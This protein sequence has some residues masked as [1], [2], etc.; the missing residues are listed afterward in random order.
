VSSRIESYLRKFKNREVYFCPNPGNAGDSLI[1][2]T[3]YQLFKKSGIKCRLVTDHDDLEGKI[4][5]YGGGGNF[6]SYY[7]N[8]S[9]F[10]SKWH[11]TVDQLIIMPSTINDH[12][13][14]LSELGKN[15]DVICRDEVSYKYV[16]LQSR[17]SNVLLMRDL[18]FDFD[19]QQFYNWLKVN[20]GNF[21][22]TVKRSLLWFL[23]EERLKQSKTL[24]SFR[25][26]SEMTEIEIP[27][28]N[29]DI[30]KLLQSDEMTEEAATVLAYNL[31]Y[32][33][34]HFT[35]INTNRLHVCI[36]GILLGKKV[37]FFPNSYYKNEAVYKYSIKDSF[38][39]V[40]WNG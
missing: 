7:N 23:A 34:G 14:L 31:L 35:Q 20:P 21:R 1:N 16:R 9:A 15:V 28:D 13:Y 4:V 37:H 38:K 11:K 36:S 24:N 27:S 40:I 26:D 3:A 22:S 39:N 17:N 12:K 29:I 32:F 8:A 10:I 33:I 18:A 19:V 2:A 5:F 6:V 25:K 30:S